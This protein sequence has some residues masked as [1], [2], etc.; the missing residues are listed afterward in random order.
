MFEIEIA[1]VALGGFLAVTLIGYQFLRKHRKENESFA[2]SH[3]ED[4]MRIKAK[5]YEN[6][7]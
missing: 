5:Q 3:V 2:R 6:G 4:A 1:L 7:N